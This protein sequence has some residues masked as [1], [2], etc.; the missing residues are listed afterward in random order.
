MPSV[1]P[2]QA[3]DPI[4]QDLVCEAPRTHE[5]KKKTESAGPVSEVSWKEFKML[6]EIQA[7][8]EGC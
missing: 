8:C 6:R 7:G 2:S 5:K 1:S 3:P 4:S